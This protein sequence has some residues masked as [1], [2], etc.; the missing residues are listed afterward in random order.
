MA[1]VAGKSGGKRAGAGRKPEPRLPDPPIP[2]QESDPL[3][4]LIS[5]MQ[6]A[7]DASALQVRAAIAAA[8]Y[9]HTK[10]ADGGKKDEVAG[11]AKKASGGKYAPAT[12]PLKLV[13]RK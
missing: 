9:V 5:V 1:G 11:A 13:G 7:V 6:G 10:R 12:A 2:T 4:F 3:A 8:Q